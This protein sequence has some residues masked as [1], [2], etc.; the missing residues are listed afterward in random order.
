MMMMMMMMMVNMNED[1]VVLG[2][3]QPAMCLEHKSSKSIPTLYHV[4]QTWVWFE[5]VKEDTEESSSP[6]PNTSRESFVLLSQFL[7]LP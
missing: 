4:N 1:K 5:N 2:M 3:S 7:E 6:S